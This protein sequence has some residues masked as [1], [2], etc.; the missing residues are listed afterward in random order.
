MNLRRHTLAWLFGLAGTVFGTYCGYASGPL[1]IVL[2]TL[3]V[4]G[5]ALAIGMFVDAAI[6]H[7][8]SGEYYSHLNNPYDPNLT[9]P[10]TPNR[11]GGPLS[12]DPRAQQYFGNHD[13]Y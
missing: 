12:L 2:G 9:K 6:A 13:G 3:L 4:G 7:P 5:L 11:F 10:L 8:G 1:G